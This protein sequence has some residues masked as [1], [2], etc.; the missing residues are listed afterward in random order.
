LQISPVSTKVD[1]GA[2]P[3]NMIVSGARYIKYWLLVLL[4][5]NF[6]IGEVTQFSISFLFGAYLLIIPPYSFWFWLFEHPLGFLF[7]WFPSPTLL[8][9][10]SVL[11]WFLLFVLL[12]VISFNYRFNLFKTEARIKSL[13]WAAVALILGINLI[14]ILLFRFR[15]ISISRWLMFFGLYFSSQKPLP[16]VGE[17]TFLA[18]SPPPSWRPRFSFEIPEQDLNI[19]YQTALDG[20]YRAT[21]QGRSVSK[22]ILEQAPPDYFRYKT[23]EIRTPKGAVLAPGTRGIIMLGPGTQGTLIS[24]T[25]KGTFWQSQITWVFMVIVFLAYL[26]NWALGLFLFILLL[27][28]PWHQSRTGGTRNIGRNM[29]ETLGG[30]DYRE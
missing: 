24:G 13:T 7:G 21:V 14:D 18:Q 25:A 1:I 19:A 17:Q 10:V 6:I 16:F 26:Y 3:G 9:S 20:A 11:L 5:P 28:P 27:L 4:F 22:E 23:E 8:G 15:M 2:A 30:I 29:C 12:T